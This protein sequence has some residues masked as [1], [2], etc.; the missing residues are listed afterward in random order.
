MIFAVQD[1]V[2]HRLANDCPG[3]LELICTTGA[4]DN[5]VSSQV[6]CHCGD[7][8][9]DDF[10]ERALA[11]DPIDET[12]PFSR[13]R[14]LS[15]RMD[16]DINEEAREIL[17][18]VGAQRQKPRHPH[19]TVAVQHVEPCEDQADPNN[20]RQE[21]AEAHKYNAQLDGIPI[22]DP[23]LL[24][25]ANDPGTQPYQSYY[26]QLDMFEAM[27]RV[28]V[29]SVDIDL[30]IYHGTTDEIIAKGAGHLY[31]TSLPVGG[32][33]T[34]SVLT[35]HTGMSNATLFDHLNKVQEGDTIFIEVS[36]ET[37]AYRVD[38][39]KII[40]PDELDDLKPIRGK[41]HLTLFTCTPYAVNTHRLLVRGERVPFTPDLAAKIA[42]ADTS[43]KMERWMWGLVGGAAAGVAALGTLIIWERR[44]SRVVGTRAAVSNP[45]QGLGNQEIDNQARRIK[46]RTDE[47]I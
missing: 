3:N 44:R 29:P 12:D 47:W 39:I 36:G 40:L 46:Q 15:G 31:G 11:L 1:S 26:G 8:I 42:D 43:F 9:V 30:P 16:C 25:A 22:L 23:W 7:G 37:L 17:L 32:E 6:L 27:G 5:R 21:I 10:S 33:G 41:D 34:H 18:R 14:F 19:A 13:G 35:S 20:L 4:I 38:Q 2:S 28:R 24:K 45:K